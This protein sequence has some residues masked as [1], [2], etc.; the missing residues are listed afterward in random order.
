[1]GGK[2]GKRKRRKK[3]AGERGSLVLDHGSICLETSPGG[4]WQRGGDVWPWH[5]GVPSHAC[6]A[7]APVGAQRCHQPGWRFSSRSPALEA[8]KD[9]E[10]TNAQ[11]WPWVTP[12]YHARSTGSTPNPTQNAKLSPGR[13]RM[14]PAHPPTP[15]ASSGCTSLAKDTHRT[16][17]GSPRPSP[18]CVEYFY[19]ERYKRDR[20]YA[21]G[22][23]GNSVC[24]QKQHG[25]QINFGDIPLPSPS[26]DFFVLSVVDNSLLSY[27]KKYLNDVQYAMP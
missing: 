19:I 15:T 12:Q 1:M 26:H 20:S 23:R 25:E 4:C 14:L 8:F 21:W 16:E 7:R 5:K 6:P 17:A 9:S 24:Q 27:I 10:S 2:F 3:G 13:A 11:T 18:E 22:R